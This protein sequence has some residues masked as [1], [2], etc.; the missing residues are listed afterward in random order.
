MPHDCSAGVRDLV[1]ACMDHNT[2]RRPSAARV[3]EL[4]A[5]AATVLNAARPPPAIDT[6]KVGEVRPEETC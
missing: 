3:V 2:A 5:G 6:G 1:Q 4:L